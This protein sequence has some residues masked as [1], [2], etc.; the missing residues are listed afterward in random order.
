MGSG[1]YRGARLGSSREIRPQAP[2]VSGPV[3]GE[4]AWPSN[5][6]EEAVAE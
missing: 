4:V 6:E 2:R 1:G 5:T 3:G